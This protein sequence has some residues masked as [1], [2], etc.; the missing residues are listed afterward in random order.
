M[1][2]DTLR[3]FSISTGRTLTTLPHLA[4]VPALETKEKEATQRKQILVLP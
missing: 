3:Y 2:N 1:I 4:R